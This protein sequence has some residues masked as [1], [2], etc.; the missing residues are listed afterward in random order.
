[1]VVTSDPTNYYPRETYLNHPDHRLAGEIALSAVFPAAGNPMFFPELIDEENLEPSPVKEIWITLTHQ[2]N[3]LLD[4]SE[5]WETKICALYEHKSQIG[6]PEKLR[7][8]QLSRHTADSTDEHPRFE[9]AFRRLVL[10]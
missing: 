2:P 4:V 3:V 7:E 10:Q 5:Y 6:E 1:V 8:R 9:E